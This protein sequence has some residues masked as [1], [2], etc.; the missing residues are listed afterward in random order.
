MKV[1]SINSG[2][3]G[4][5]NVFDLVMGHSLEMGHFWKTDLWNWNWYN[6]T[7]SSTNN[8]VITHIIGIDI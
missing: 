4:M 3:N 1:H 5:S 6:R 8:L 2:V 7:S